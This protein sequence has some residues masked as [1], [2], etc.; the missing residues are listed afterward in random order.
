MSTTSTRVPASLATERRT[1]VRNIAIIAHV[2]HG[3]TT[4][5]DCLLRQSGEFRASQLVGDC[6]LDSNDLER[7][8]GITILAKNIALHYHGVKINIIDTPGHADFG[9]EVERVL[10]MADGALVLVDAAEGPMPQTRYVLSKALEC[11]LQPIVVVNKIDRPDAR[12]H[13]VLNES[14]ELLMDLG[15]E[16]ILSDFPHIFATSKGGYATHDPYVPGDSMKPLF[17]LML[18]AIPGPE[19]DPDAP[20][21]ML[22]TNLDWSDYVG[23]IAIGRIYSG[24]IRT[25]QQVALMQADDQSISAKVAEV[26]VFDKLGRTQ[27]E[28]ATAGDIAAL[29]GLEDVTIGDTVSDPQD[30]Q[31]LPRVSVDEPTIQ[32]VFS[33]NNSPFAGREG[34]YV[35]SQH[36][37]ARLRKEL[38]RNV[39]LRVEPM[40]SMDSFQVFGRGVLHLAVLIETMR[41][42]GYELSISKPHVVLHHNNGVTEEPFE[43][44]VV[45]V[46]HDKLGPVMEL[47]G[48]RRGQLVE[49]TAHDT[50]TY[51][52]FS[53][54]ARG[55]I[56]LRTRLLNATQGTAVIHHRFERFAPVEGEIPDRL[57]GV[58]VSMVA[59]RVVAYGLDTLQERAEMFVA[60]GDDVYEG[61]IVGENSRSEDMT[62]NPTKEKKLTNMRATGSD[63]NILLKPPRIMSLEMALEYIEEDELVEV[64]PTSIRLRK[65]ILK[66]ADRRRLA[67]RGA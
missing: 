53:I 63:K 57:N 58:L 5:V 66:E 7:E 8:R 21:R 12:A 36:L 56:G 23:R 19:I 3:K 61:M 28:V 64:T 51:V 1:D 17:D 44:L 15:G 41:R 22:V 52:V 43:S 54:P 46:P 10:R 9:G 2:D 37:A 32:M 65:K 49:M 39:A 18:E 35:T 67:R 38:E 50:Y 60:P 29:V 11:R 14:F 55:L 13:E 47:V 4:L 24:S 16:H 25:G 45:E 6:I 33:I 27:V 40:D 48:A 59:G 42:E 31:A 62:V 26:H 34:K 20:L 30:R